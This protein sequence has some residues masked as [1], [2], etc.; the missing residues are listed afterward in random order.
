MVL[1][2]NTTYKERKGRTMTQ[3]ISQFISLIRPQRKMFIKIL[4]VYVVYEAL[5]IVPTVLLREIVDQLRLGLSADMIMIV[6]FAV[7]MLVVDLFTMGIVDIWLDRRIFDLL[8]WAERSLPTRVQEKMMHLSLGYHER[9]QTGEKITSLQRGTDK[10]VQ[11]LMNFLWTLWPLMIEVTWAIVVMLWIDVQTTIIFA[12]AIPVFIAMTWHL[13]VR[14]LEN[15]KEQEDLYTKSS[16][17]LG[18]SVI[19]IKT[20]QAFAQEGREQQE[21]GH[22]REQIERLGHDRMMLHTRMN[23]WRGSVINAARLGI[24]LLAGYKV[25]TGEI[26][27]GS[28]V[29]FLM[30]SQSVFRSLFNL[31]QVLDRMVEAS[32]PLQRLFELLQEESEIVIADKPTRPHAWHGRIDFKNVSFSYDGESRALD[33]V[34]FVVESGETVALCGPSGGGKSTIVKLLFRY[35]DPMSGRIEVDGHELRDLDIHALRQQTGYVPQEVEVMS[36]TI[37]ENITYG[38]PEATQEQV[39]AAARLAHVHDFV[40]RLPKAYD[41]VVGERG[42]KL[43][44]GQRQRLGIAR[45]LLVDPTILVFDEATSNLDAAAERGIQQALDDVAGKK[46][47]IV[48]AHRL[49]TIM[50][51]DKIIVV[52]DGQIA[53]VGTHEELL[54]RNGLYERLVRLQTQKE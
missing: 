37:W 40:Q 12:A 27:I 52:K 25:Y 24:I 3:F 28:I 48:V 10:L 2:K 13:H 47:L 51:A 54:K 4:L 41:T 29:L 23:F 43:S 26:S 5:L 31:N 7:A 53:E 45:A 39:L 36:G 18:E 6:Q 30:L 8:Y 46:T 33:D 20:V 1:E 49:S 34:S 32:E 17:R 15:R 42:M 19:H 44:G 50:K 21:Y 14:T 38:N 11:L 16:G 9:Q 35:Y 22:L